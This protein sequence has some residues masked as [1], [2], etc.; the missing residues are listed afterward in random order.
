MLGF[1]KLEN[2]T[3][4]ANNWATHTVEARNMNKISI[5]GAYALMLMNYEACNVRHDE[6]H[7]MG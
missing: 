5:P 7:L 3:Y 2:R 4:M 6:M 1:L